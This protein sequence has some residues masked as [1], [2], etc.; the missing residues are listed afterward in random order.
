M[1]EIAPS[2]PE[3]AAP[4]FPHTPPVP[5]PPHM[6]P[7]PPAAETAVPVASVRV[8]VQCKLRKDTHT[9]MK[10]LAVATGVDMQDQIQTAL[11]EHFERHPELMR[12]LSDMGVP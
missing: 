5:P 1:E 3:A 8:R 2:A 10:H 6:P 7:Q 11:D 4:Q 9:R 12:I